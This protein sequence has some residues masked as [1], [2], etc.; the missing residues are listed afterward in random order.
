GG[1]LPGGVVPGGGGRRGA[2][3]GPRPVGLPPPRLDVPPRPRAL[4]GVSPVAAPVRSRRARLRP[5]RPVARLTSVRAEQAGPV[6]GLGASGLASAVRERAIAR[7]SVVAGQRPGVDRER[8]C[9]G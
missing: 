7:I 9:V 4:L 1:G 6:T 8:A 2:P 3:G 5:R